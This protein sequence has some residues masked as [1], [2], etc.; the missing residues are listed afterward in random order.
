MGW[1]FQTDPEFEE[2]LAWMREFVREEVEPLDAIADQ[3]DQ[4]QLVALLAPL[5]EFHYHQH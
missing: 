2:T 1:D 3:L 4:T 5:Q